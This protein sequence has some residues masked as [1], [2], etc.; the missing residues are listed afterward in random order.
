MKLFYK[1]Y[2]FLIIILIVVLGWSG[3]IVYQREVSHFN[4]D[5]KNHALLLGKAMSG[6]IKHTWKQFDMEMALTLISDVNREEHQ[7]KLRWIWLDS[8]PG[9]PY[10]P[11]AP[12]KLLS[13]VFKGENVSLTMDDDTGETFRFTYIP[14]RVDQNH[15]GALEISESL[16]MMKQYNHDS[17]MHLLYTGVVLLL[18]IGGILWHRFQIWIHQPLK[19]FIEKSVKIG[20]GNLTPDLVVKGRDEF[21]LLAVTLNDMCKNLDATLKDIRIAHEKRIAALEQ[22]RHTERLATLGRLSAGVA[23]EL[24]TPLNVISGRSKMI[25]AGDLE[26][27]E[28]LDNARIIGEQTYRMTQII[29]GLLNFARRSHPNRQL[30]DMGILVR[31]VVEMLTST[32][33]KAKVSLDFVQEED[34]SRIFIDFTQIQQVLTN[35]IMNGIQAMPY[36]GSLSLTLSTVNTHHPDKISADKKYLAV[37]VEDEGEG[38]AKG[39]IAHLF[40]PFFTTKDVGQGSGLG[41]S[42]AFGI[43]EEHG[44]WIHVNN[45]SEKGACFTVFLPMENE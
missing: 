20:E 16:R 40:E 21:S 43:V 18:A 8:S 45:R 25:R 24:G 28:V 4:N 14:V 35:L 1:V 29:R 32:A 39:N 2:I 31:K 6:P 36:G 3:Y 26:Q 34:L 11:R 41:L 22:L 38:I 15:P 27:V 10:F 30:E 42:I 44:G 5:M 23:H 19:R 12:L 9:E 33:M 13:N 37:Q 7:M 17:F